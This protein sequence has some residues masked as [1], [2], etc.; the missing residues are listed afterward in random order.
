MLP[1]PG[2]IH[3]WKTSK[4]TVITLLLKH[5]LLKE[6]IRATTT[7]ASN[8]MFSKT[9]YHTGKLPGQL[10]DLREMII[11][12]NPLASSSTGLRLKENRRKLQRSAVSGG[13]NANK[14]TYNIRQHQNRR[15]NEP[16]IMAPTKLL[17]TAA[18]AETL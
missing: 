4:I 5:H 8:S 7:P 13:F 14:P 9:N 12:L 10:K 1:L 17:K 11:F 3:P 18:A 2:Q 15:T 6:G 16:I